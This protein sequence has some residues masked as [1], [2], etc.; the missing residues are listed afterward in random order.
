MSSADAIA[1]AAS[2]LDKGAFKADLAR[3][4]A[5]QTESQNPQRAGELRRCYPGHDYARARSPGLPLPD[6]DAPGR[7]RPFLYAERI[8][9][10][11]LPAVLC[12]GHGGVNWGPEGSWE[13]GRSPAHAL[14]AALLCRLFAART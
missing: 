1:R 12:Y 7:A 6:H 13:D 11:R 14:S 8:E 10:A 9:Y 5:I 3:R 2:H 4:I